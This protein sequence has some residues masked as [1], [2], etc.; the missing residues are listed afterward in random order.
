MSNFR[1][2]PVTLLE[3]Q[4]EFTDLG[5]TV[6]IAAGAT[7]PAY[8]LVRITST[9]A[10]NLTTGAS[11]DLAYAFEPATDPFFIAEG[12]GNSQVKNRVTVGHLRGIRIG[13]TVLG[14]WNNARIGEKHPVKLDTGGSGYAVIDPADAVSTD[15]ATI[16]AVTGDHARPVISGTSTNV[17]VEAILDDTACYSL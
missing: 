17:Y 1:V 9:G 5:R 13:I 10:A 6:N 14:V 12:P 8:N 16:I 2:R 15:V 7:F 3:S 11:T 4:G